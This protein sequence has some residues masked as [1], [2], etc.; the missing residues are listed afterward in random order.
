MQSAVS[1]TESSKKEIP[2]EPKE[3]RQSLS[4]P[5]NLRSKSG[6]A[7]IDKT[8]LQNELKK[9]Q[10]LFQKLEK[11]VAEL[12]AKKEELE[13]TLAHPDTYSNGVEFK[14]TEAA[15]KDVSVKF[16]A[17]TKEYEI[18]FEKMISLD[19]ALLA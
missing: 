8:V 18:V 14:K 1:S 12:T 6:Q 4:N 13:A 17:A 9:Q 19:E 11:D 3:S 10:K 5:D 7:A 2:E 16:I 15:Y